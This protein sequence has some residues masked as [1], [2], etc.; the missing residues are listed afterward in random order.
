MASSPS[1]EEPKELRFWELFGFA[2]SFCSPSKIDCCGNENTKAP[3]SE[4]D[5]VAVPLIAK[6]PYLYYQEE[7]CCAQY[8]EVLPAVS[9]LLMESSNDSSLHKLMC[10]L[11]IQ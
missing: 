10:W 3:E 4:S 8:E 11:K 7:H 6:D 9:F 1:L 5:A 2:I